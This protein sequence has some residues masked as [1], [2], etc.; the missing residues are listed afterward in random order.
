[1]VAFVRKS[2]DPETRRGNFV[3]ILEWLRNLSEKNEMPLHETCIMAL[4]RLARY[5]PAVRSRMYRLMIC[6]CRLS[7]DDEMNL[8]LLRLLEYL[9]HPNPFVCA[10]AYTEVRPCSSNC[11]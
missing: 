2:L 10:V 3:I 4:C 5:I 7:D 11:L 9:G 1:M 6:K 8:V